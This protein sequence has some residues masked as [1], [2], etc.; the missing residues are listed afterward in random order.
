MTLVLPEGKILTCGNEQCIGFTQ[1]EYKVVLN[2]YDRYVF[3]SANEPLYD[4][5]DQIQAEIK[6]TMGERFALQEGTILI[7]KNEMERSYKLYKADVADLNHQL[8]KQKVQSV[9]GYLGCGVAG[10]GL[11]IL[12]G[13]LVAPH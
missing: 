2:I 12:I 6:A 3:W 8:R 13:V 1:D 10:V 7:L 9:I 5:L 11:G 4:R